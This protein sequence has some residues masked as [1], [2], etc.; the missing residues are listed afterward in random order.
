MQPRSDVDGDDKAVRQDLA[1]GLT[2]NNKGGRWHGTD[3]SGVT[4]NV[5]RVGEER[6]ASW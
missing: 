6:R 2:D 1:F 4:G 3:V 5:C